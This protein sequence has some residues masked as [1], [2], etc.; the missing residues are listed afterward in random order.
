ME[1]SPSKFDPLMLSMLVDLPMT[2]GLAQ[3]QLRAA[4]L[5]TWKSAL[6]KGVL[7]QSDRLA[8]PIDPFKTQFMVRI[9]IAPR[10]RC[11]TSHD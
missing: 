10:H 5:Q 6:Q 11:A 7:P 4:S 2:D 8:F 1:G 3:F 9:P